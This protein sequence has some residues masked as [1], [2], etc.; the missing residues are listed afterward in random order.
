M[1]LRARLDAVATEQKHFAEAV[2]H[3]RLNPDDGS[4]TMDA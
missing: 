2:L 3:R 4:E 1:S